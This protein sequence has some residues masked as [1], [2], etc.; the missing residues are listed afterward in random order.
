MTI[1]NA[2]PNNIHNGDPL[3][4]VAVM[5]NFNQIVSNVNAGAAGLTA[6]NIFTQPQNGVAAILPGQFTLLSQVQALIAAAI[7]TG[8]IMDFG[9]GAAPTGFAL[10]DG[11]AVSRTDPVYSG[12]FAVIGTVWGAGNGVSTYNLPNMARRATIGSGG[13]GTGTIGNA[14]GSYGG[15]ENHVLAGGELANHIHGIA[16]PG[17]NHSFTDPGHSHGVNDPTHAHAI[18]DPGHAHG[19]NGNYMSNNL[20]GGSLNPI[21]AFSFGVGGA[22][23]GAGTGIGIY[24]AA[25]GISLYVSGTGAYP[26]GAY[27]GINT[28]QGAGSNAA[29]N[30]MQPSAVVTKVIKL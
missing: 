6:T 5:A 3:D 10:C 1:I 7:P 11:S 22:T 2:L 28:T 30:T 9:G 13:T 12:L 24:G 23:N 17:H 16:D 15:E 20:T 8:M 19:I 25:T 18:A 21:G 26:N 27:T 14:T 29:H 4:A